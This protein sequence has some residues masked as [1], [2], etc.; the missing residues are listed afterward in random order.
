MHACAYT[1]QPI[2]EKSENEGPWR[3]YSIDDCS[4]PAIDGGV[5]PFRGLGIL[6][7][8]LS[9]TVATLPATETSAPTIEALRL[10]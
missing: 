8:F 1:E 2:Q 6:R 3:F 5:A 7:F 4:G 9:K 10:L